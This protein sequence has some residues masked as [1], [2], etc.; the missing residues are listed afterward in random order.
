MYYLYLYKSY[1]VKH[2]IFFHSAL[3]CR[4]HSNQKLGVNAL[5]LLC[6]RQIMNKDLLYSTGNSTQHPVISYMR[7]QSKKNESMYMCN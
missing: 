5:T 1:Y 7:K 6:I 4:N 2:S 3:C